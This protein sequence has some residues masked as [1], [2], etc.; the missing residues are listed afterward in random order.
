MPP[1]KK[2]KSGNPN[3]RPKGTPNRVKAIRDEIVD[4]WFESSEKDGEPSGKELLKALKV[5]DPPTY[6][7]VVGPLVAKVIPD[8]TPAIDLH[9][10]VG[11]ARVADG[12]SSG[13]NGRNVSKGKRNGKGASRLRV[14]SE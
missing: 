8:E 13:G 2:G 4:T 7:K 9:V 12:G 1:F 3:G 6:L 5:S 14:P 11:A 10:T